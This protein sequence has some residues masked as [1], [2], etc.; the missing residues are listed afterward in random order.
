MTN[1]ALWSMVDGGAMPPRMP[2]VLI[3]VG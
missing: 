2:R 3:I 1:L